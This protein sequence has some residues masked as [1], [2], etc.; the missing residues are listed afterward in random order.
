MASEL[1]QL[2]RAPPHLLHLCVNPSLAH[3]AALLTVRYWLLW[4]LRHSRVMEDLTDPEARQSL[5]LSV[6]CLLLAVGPQ[7][8]P[9]TSLSLSCEM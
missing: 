8:S 9:L 2:P 6:H 1:G 3:S 5:G 4:A 7:S